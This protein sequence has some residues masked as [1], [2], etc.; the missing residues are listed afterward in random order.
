MR[1]RTAGFAAAVAEGAA[2]GVLLP[3]AG[4]EVAVDAGEVLIE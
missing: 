3:E 2:A 4:S 1:S